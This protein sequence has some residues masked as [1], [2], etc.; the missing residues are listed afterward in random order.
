[1]YYAHRVI[2][3]PVGQL[4]GETPT[5]TVIKEFPDI[6]VAITRTQTLANVNMQ[7]WNFGEYRDILPLLID[8]VNNG[9]TFGVDVE[10]N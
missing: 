10:N 1:V 8:K 5:H 3:F 6:K 2:S 4:S 9:F 7:I